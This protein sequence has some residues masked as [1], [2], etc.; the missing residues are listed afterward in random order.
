ML[1]FALES[2]SHSGERTGEYRFPGG[3]LKGSQCADALRF[4]W[5]RSWELEFEGSVPLELE[6]GSMAILWSQVNKSRIDSPLNAPRCA[7]CGPIEWGTAILV[8]AVIPAKYLAVFQLS[9]SAASVLVAYYAVFI[10]EV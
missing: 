5:E 9:R 1:V 8:I 2:S 3:S 4:W 6:P 10:A 7:S